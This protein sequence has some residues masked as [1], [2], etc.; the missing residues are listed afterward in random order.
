MMA[1]MQMLDTTA[2]HPAGPDFNV[3]VPDFGYRWWYVDGISDDGRDGIV[4]IAFI[5]SV[6]SPYYYRAR[7]RGRGDPYEYCALN[8]SLYGPRGRRWTMTERGRNDL[9]LG[10]AQGRLGPSAVAWRDGMLH[11]DVCERSAPLD[12]AR[13]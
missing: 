11:I 10:D 5:G 8:V 9:H 3:P 2:G 1:P 6:F 12:P 7:A 4:V 13:R